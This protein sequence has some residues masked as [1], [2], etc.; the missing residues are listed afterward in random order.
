[1]IIR[2]SVL[3]LFR[4][5]A[6]GLSIII[7]SPLSWPLWTFLLPSPL[8]LSPLWVLTR[9]S[10]AALAVST[11]IAAVEDAVAAVAASLVVLVLLVVLV[12][13]V[14]RV[15]VALLALR[16]IPWPGRLLAS[17]TTTGGLET[18]LSD[19]T[20]AAAAGRETSFPGVPQRRYSRS[21][22]LHL[23]PDIQ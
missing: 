19:A 16:R 11:R 22:G 5:T 18:A 9:P 3:W 4:R 17:A 20:A 1:M 10:R 23:G 6:F 13:L 14:L 7:S 15:L 2:T 8:L 12:R 21:S